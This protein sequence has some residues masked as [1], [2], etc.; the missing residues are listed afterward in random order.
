MVVD[1]ATPG[2][3]M[4]LGAVSIVAHFAFEAGAALAKD[5][6]GEHVTAEQIQEATTAWARAATMWQT[7]ET[8]VTHELHI[9][10]PD[11]TDLSLFEQIPEVDSNISVQ[12]L[13]S[14]FACC[15]LMYAALR[16]RWGTSDEA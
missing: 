8:T 9:E 14:F 4:C 2:S 5:L 13:I 11:L 1:P 12:V 3:K 16:L 15:S 10:E 6:T 7:V